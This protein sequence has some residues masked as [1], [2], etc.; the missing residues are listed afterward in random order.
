MGDRPPT[1]LD[2]LDDD[3]AADVLAPAT[4]KFII[5]EARELLLPV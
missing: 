4:R 1:L 3:V 5:I 2:L